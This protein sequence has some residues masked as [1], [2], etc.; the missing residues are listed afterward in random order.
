MLQLPDG[1]KN[2]LQRDDIF[3]VDR[4]FR[5]V[6]PVL[7]QNGFEI[8]MP[9]LKGKRNQLTTQESNQSRLVTKTRWIVEAIHSIIGQKFKLLH[10]QLN[11]RH[12]PNVGLFC[13]IA[14]FLQNLF[15]KR[16]NSDNNKA[17][18][19]VE[20][21]NLTMNDV[22]T[23]AAEVEANNWNR[24]TTPFATVTSKELLDFPELTLSDLEIFFT[25]SY[26]LKQSLSYLA[27]L[28]GDNNSFLQNYVK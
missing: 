20:R 2:I 17:E 25:G 7:E 13:K 14:Y 16:L 12:L 4:G 21:M 3:I 9:A 5:D 1:L 26:Q 24:K 18:E 28:L 8:L 27:E 19:I 22:N 6:R 11:N 10:Y 15:G 23:L